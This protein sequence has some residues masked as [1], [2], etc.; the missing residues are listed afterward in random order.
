MS[1]NPTPDP[2]DPELPPTGQA[3]RPLEHLVATMEILDPYAHGRLQ[4]VVALTRALLPA[5]GIQ[6]SAAEAI[7]LA[8]RVYEVG[9][10]T[11]SPYLVIQPGWLLE[12]DQGLLETHAAAG[13][14][15]VL[16][17]SGRADVAAIVRSHHERW[18]GLGYPDG[19]CGPAI[20]QGARVL[21]V[22]DSFVALTSSRRSRE[23]CSVEEA[24]GIL[25]EGR[26]RQWDPEVVDAFVESVIKGPQPGGTAHPGG[27]VVLPPSPPADPDPPPRAS[28]ALLAQ[29][30]HPPQWRGV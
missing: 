4:R 12:A 23:A 13:A 9:K 22:V 11:L 2:I 10:I 30:G 21:A 14:A 25:R 19:L 15:L 6:G 3:H 27:R 1:T 20:P 26:G 17:R 28:A 18:D 16:A 5:L 29:W 8:A 24:I 7:L